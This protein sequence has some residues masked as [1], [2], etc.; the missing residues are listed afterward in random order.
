MEHLFGKFRARRRI[1]LL[2]LTWGLILAAMAAYTAA[3][4]DAAWACR[5]YDGHRNWVVPPDCS[6]YSSGYSG[7]SSVDAAI[8][9]VGLPPV[10]H[11][12]AERESGDNPYA[13]NPVSGA[14]GPFQ[15]L[16]STAAAYGYTCYELTDPYTAA[17]AAK[18]LYNDSGLA[19]WS[20][21][22]Y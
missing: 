7:A 21:T 13:V 19:P 2:L 4:P 14:C 17:T 6:G 18:Q 10:F 11:A 20:L 1:A 12:I 5:D 16:P 15:F 3:A 9:S 22:T 8:D